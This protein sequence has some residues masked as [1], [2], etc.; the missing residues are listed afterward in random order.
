MSGLDTVRSWV[1]SPVWRPIIVALFGFSGVILTQAVVGHREARRALDDTAREE[2]RWQPQR[3]AR[4]HEARA[5]AYAQLMGAIE[6]FDA[7]LFQA[8]R[9]REAGIK[10]RPGWDAR[11]RGYR[12]PRVH[13]RLDLGFD[14]EEVDHNDLP[15]TD[16]HRGG[17]GIQTGH[18]IN[19][20]E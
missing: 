3:E 6:A 17:R 15:R 13:M 11:Q 5:A 2:R 12:V 9:V 14:A 16:H 18:S 8:R 19:F 4:T 10:T 7:V 20:R 1:S